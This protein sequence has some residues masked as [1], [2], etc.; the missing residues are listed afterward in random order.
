MDD[1]F[2]KGSG[3]NKQTDGNNLFG[4]Q[5]QIQGQNTNTNILTDIFSNPNPNSFNMFGGQTPNTGTGYGDFTASGSTKSTGSTT[6]K[7]EVNTAE[8]LSSKYFD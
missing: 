1:I 8:L 6:N 4:N 5:N 2:G 7:G 3:D